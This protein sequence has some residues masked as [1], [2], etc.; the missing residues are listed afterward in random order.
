MS[1][2]VVTKADEQALASMLRRRG[3]NGATVDELRSLLFGRLCKRAKVRTWWIGIDPTLT[4]VTSLAVPR[5]LA[6]W[7]R[8][9][10][11]INPVRG[12]WRWVS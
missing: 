2:I 8:E 10:K 7:K 6:K 12:R 1:E 5:I 4:R 11:A 9:G 3:E